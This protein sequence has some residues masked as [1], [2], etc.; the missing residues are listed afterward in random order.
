MSKANDAVIITSKLY[1]PRARANLV[2]RPR[3]TQQIAASSSK[4]VLI[5]APPGFGKTTLLSEWGAPARTASELQSEVAAAGFLVL[6][7]MPMPS[8]QFS[9]SRGLLL[10]RKAD[11]T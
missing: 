6:R 10:A 8:G 4:L 11:T 2:E 5:S 7:S 1:V 9:E 3:L